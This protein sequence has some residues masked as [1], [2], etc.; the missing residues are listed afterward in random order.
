MSAKRVGAG[1]YF[2]VNV[3]EFVLRILSEA[4]GGERKFLITFFDYK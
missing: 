1:A 3:Y 2:I 4:G